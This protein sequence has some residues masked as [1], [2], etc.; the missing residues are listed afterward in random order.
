M[1][2]A[3]SIYPAPDGWNSIPRTGSSA[4]V[5][6]SE[7]RSRAMRG[8]PF[9]CTA[10]TMATER[11]KREWS[12]RSGFE[13]WETIRTRE[14]SNADRS[15]LRHHFSVPGADAD[16]A[17]A[18]HPS[19]ARRRPA[20]ARR[21]LFRP[22]LRHARLSRSLR[23]SRHARRGS[24]RPDEIPPDAEL[25]PIARLPDEVLLYLVSSRYCDSDNLADFA[26][27]K[28]HTITGGWRR[29]QAICDFVHAQIRFSYPEARPTRT[30]SDAM[31]EGVGVCRDFAH[32]AVALCRCMNI[33]ARYCTG[34]LGDIGVPVDPNPMDFSAWFEVFLDGRWFTMD[35]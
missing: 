27:S 26:W 33:P 19:H 20:L 4:I 7:S 15:R 10:S 8:K 5:T 22:I 25:A 24:R 2:G 14:S 17:A 21:H 28:F 1:L 16:A 18:Q 13:V 34:Y 35:A 9:P 3:K 29:A 30:A 31:R 23:Q 32:L 6:S 11:T 12:S